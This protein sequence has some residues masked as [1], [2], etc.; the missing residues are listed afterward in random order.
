MP[1]RVELNLSARA[2]TRILCGL[3][4]SVS[5]HLINMAVRYNFVSREQDNIKEIDGGVKNKW[6]WSWCEAKLLSG[7]PDVHLVSDCFRKI[8]RPGEA[9]C[10]Y[11]QVTIK[12]GSSGKKALQQ[13]AEKFQKHAEIFRIKRTN[14]QLPGNDFEFFILK[15][16]KDTLRNS[17]VSVEIYIYYVEIRFPNSSPMHTGRRYTLRWL[18]KIGLNMILSLVVWHENTHQNWIIAHD[19]HN[20]NTI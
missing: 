12:Y 9:F 18:Y 5:I 13:H 17:K 4:L 8:D 16:L 10:E 6:N 14:Y 19:P 15:K 11:C 2:Y 3:T 1:Y 20:S 7:T